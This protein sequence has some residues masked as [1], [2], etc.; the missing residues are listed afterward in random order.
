M[1]EES[2]TGERA[3]PPPG[4]EAPAAVPAREPA[5]EPERGGPAEPGAPGGSRARAVRAWHAGR[6]DPWLLAA[7]FC[8]GYAAVS[9]T[10]WRR[11]E[12]RSWDLGIFE[13]VI[14]SYAR[15][16]APVSDLKG[17]GFPILGD[18]F[19]P[20][21]A[22]IAP[23]Y[24]LF[25][26]PVTLLVAQAALFALAVVPVTRAAAHL[27]GRA[28]GA[29][30]GAAFGLSWGIQRAVDFDFHEI[31]FAVPLIAF[32]LEAVLRER[33]R[34]ALCWALPLLLVKE[35]LGLTAAAI[36]CVVALRAGPAD[37]RTARRALAVAAVCVVG[38]AL[39]LTVVIPSFNAGGEYDYWSKLG[40]SGA[41]G[42]GGPFGALFTGAEEKLRTLLW[43]LVPTTGLLALRSPLL[44]VALPTMGWRFVSQ[45][46][47]YW[48]TDWH[49][50]A[51]LMPV[52]ALAL[53]D[54]VA[55]GRSSSRPWL[56]GYAHHLPAAVLAAALALSTALPAADLTR[57]E[58]YR[59]GPLAAAGE[60]VM[61]AVPDGA[62]VAA[63]VRPI[64]H[65]T[66]RCRVF[67]IGGSGDLVPD[68]IAYYDPGHTAESLTAYAARLY[69]QG[70]R[71]TVAAQESGFFV[72]RAEGA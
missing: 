19:S 22:L 60:R 26:G 10:R 47:H 43:I 68:W 24:R 41:E 1:V 14:S 31:A 39:T 3:D 35:D 46:P 27:L 20:V 15:L 50:S 57:A 66:Q 54:A 32:A 58:T 12:N 40:E 9:V 44:L 42:G 6:L 21:T 8:A 48:S 5:D 18:H 45:D 17:P 70:P 49:Y 69:P 30:V 16:E 33:W 2:R 7:V 71:W 56:R 65:L 34:A 64:A 67:W 28:R 37:P 52:L 72:L 51:V 36:A 62:E 29:A 11:W 61:A 4:A 53:T 63:N 59:A 25:P 38:C 55:R 23:F 13:Q